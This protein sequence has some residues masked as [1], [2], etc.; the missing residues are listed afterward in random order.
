LQGAVDKL[1][2]RLWKDFV[3]TGGKDDTPTSPGCRALRR[4]SLKL[5]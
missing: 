3:M 4:G 2:M 1:K 5:S